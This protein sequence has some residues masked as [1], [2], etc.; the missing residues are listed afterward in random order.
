MSKQPSSFD[1]LSNLIFIRL[2]QLKREL[3]RTGWL[4]SL[5]LLIIVGIFGFLFYFSDF[6]KKNYSPFAPKSVLT[7]AIFRT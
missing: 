7:T 3:I 5:I 2:Q 1:M 6:V 4:Y